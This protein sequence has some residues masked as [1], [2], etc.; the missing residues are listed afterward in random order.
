[1]TPSQDKIDFFDKLLVE[2]MSLSDADAE[3]IFRQ[4][5]REYLSKLSIEE[6]KDELERIRRQNNEQR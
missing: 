2:T 6:A 3:L 4:Q 5:I 1:M